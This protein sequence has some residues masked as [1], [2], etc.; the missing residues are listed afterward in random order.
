MTSKLSKSVLER[1]KKEDIKPLPKY[2]FVL[3]NVLWWI[4]FVASILLGAAGLA[5]T[6]FAFMHQ[7]FEISDIIER[8]QFGSCIPLLPFFWIFFFGVFIWLSFWGIT[9]TKKAYR[10]PRVFLIGLNV[11]L[12]L[13]LGTVIYTAR[14]AEKFEHMIGKQMLQM[15]T[16]REIRTERWKKGVEEGRLA[17]EIKEILDSSLVVISLDEKDWQVDISETEIHPDVVLEVG[18]KIGMRGQKTGEATF[19]AEKMRPWDPTLRPIKRI[20]DKDGHFAP[21]GKGER[22]G[23]A[24]LEHPGKRGEM[25]VE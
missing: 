24:F 8:G 2:Y 15:P 1:I 10:I 20:L 13:L 4:A 5:V 16:V 14:Q 19:K 25:G 11:F 21:K 3:R 6:M 22:P 7:R 18:S 9:H 12:T 17:G 23:K